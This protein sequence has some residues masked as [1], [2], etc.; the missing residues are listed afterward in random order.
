V[1]LLPHHHETPINIWTTTRC[2]LSRLPLVSLV[3]GALL[4]TLEDPFDC[5][6]SGLGLV[7][8]IV[9]ESCTLP[10][11]D[12]RNPGDRVVELPWMRRRGE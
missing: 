6:V 11:E 4:R 3:L 10:G 7:S 1:F 8:C 9:R 12:S 2:L 5:T